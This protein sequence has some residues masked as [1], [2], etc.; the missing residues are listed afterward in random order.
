MDLFD[1]AS[2]LY[3]LWMA[4]VTVLL[5]CLIKWVERQDQSVSNDVVETTEFLERLKARQE[6]IERDS[7][8]GP[9]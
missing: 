2:A 8:G 1:L 7:Q 3:V 4:V 5:I 6:Q 9:K